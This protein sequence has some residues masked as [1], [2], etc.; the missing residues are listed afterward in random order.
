MHH[1]LDPLETPYNMHI[2]HGLRSFPFSIFLLESHQH[3]RTTHPV[4][5][6]GCTSVVEK[7]HVLRPFRGQRASKQIKR[8]FSFIFF[9]L[10]THTLYHPKACQRLHP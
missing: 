9:F 7:S 10:F 4:C 3:L 2:Y 5:C 1:T 6:D 8:C